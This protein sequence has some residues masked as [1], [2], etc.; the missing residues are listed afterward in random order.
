[1]KKVFI[2][3]R[4][5]TLVELMIVIAI[6][7]ILVV[8][9]IPKMGFMRDTAKASGLDA[10]VRVVQSTVLSMIDKYTTTNMNGTTRGTLEYDLQQKIDGNMANPF[11]GSTGVA[12]YPGTTGLA[13]YTYN[14]PYSNW[15]GTYPA[16]A[17]GV[18]CALTANGSKIRAEIYYI[19]K[20]GY[21]SPSTA[22]VTVDQ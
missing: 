8:V 2:N 12:R 3:E 10:N 9:L 1:M 21:P 18:V 20:N 4:G 14:G 11:S 6:I 17:G 13:L 19:D 7:S 5:F 22:V 16:Q 15:T